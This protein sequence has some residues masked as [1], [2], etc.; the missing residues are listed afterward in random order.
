MHIEHCTLHN[1]AM[2]SAQ[3]YISHVL[4]TIL[5]LRKQTRIKAFKFSTKIQ[6]QFVLFN[7]SDDFCW[8]T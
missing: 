3:K 2:I 5:I 6:I 8:K 1:I 4:S 7:V